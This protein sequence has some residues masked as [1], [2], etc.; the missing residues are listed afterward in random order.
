[1]VGGMPMY[2]GEGAGTRP[3]MKVNVEAVSACD[4]HILE[5]GL[6]KLSLADAAI[7][8]TAT[9]K[10]ERILAC[11]GEI[12][13]E[14]SIL[15]LETIYCEGTTLT[16]SSTSSD[17]G[18]RPNSTE[19]RIKLRISAPIVDFGETTE[20]FPTERTT[21]YT[22]F[23]DVGHSRT[24]PPPPPL[25]QVSIPPYC[26][27]DGLGGAKRGRSRVVVSGGVGRRC[28]AVSVR[29]VP[30]ATSV[31]DRLGNDKGKD[32]GGSGSEEDLV[33]LGKA[34][35]WTF[36][37]G[38]KDTVAAGNGEAV[39]AKLRELTCAIDSSKGN[40]MI[41]SVGVM[42][43][44]CIVGVAPSKK[45]YSE[46][47]ILPKEG[48][49]K[50]I[51]ND[52][53]NEYANTNA[54]VQANVNVAVPGKLEYDR[55]QDY[56]RNAG[57]NTISSTTTSATVPSPASIEG[58]PTNTNTGS[59]TTTDDCKNKNSDEV[60]YLDAIACNIWKSEMHG[61][62]VAGFRS[63][64]A[65]GP[66]CEEPIR[67]ILV[68]LEGV[69]IALTK[70][71]KRHKKKDVV[72]VAE[73]SSG[74]ES[75]NTTTAPTPPISTNMKCPIATSPSPSLLP[76]YQI[77][78]PIA[79]G[80]IIT[81]LQTSIRSSLLTRPT[82]LVEHHLHLTLHSSLTGLGPLHSTLSRRRGT[83]LTD[84]MVD[85][86]TLLSITATI[87]QINSFGLQAELAKKSSGEVTAPE[88]GSSH[89][90]V[91]SEDPFWIPTS[92]EEREE[93]GEIEGSG[94][95]S[96]GVGNTALGY[97]RMVRERKGLMVDDKRIVVVAEKQRTLARKK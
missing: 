7:E 23:Y 26:Y 44:R 81:T 58:N 34:L 17:G 4:T 27:E 1:M 94:D 42:D 6:A 39:L 71:R 20:W 18:G 31:W 35:G 86:T 62:A 43:G 49:S 63:S 97:I 76:T 74:G 12:H 78:K 60:K 24:I 5:K 91:L 25:R 53:M 22:S 21:D 37:D 73:G 30:L 56:I 38:E 54:N 50:G 69:E 32:K 66:L 19:T 45:N 55:M 96:T 84:T 29:V 85:G 40:C 8:V 51:E 75:N 90:G 65:A 14:Q 89:W 11:Q 36:E 16:N 33:L 93:Y 9:S 77:A 83:V 80:M 67:G 57:Q 70:I 82:R 41:E 95:C 15:D 47:Y 59:V 46:V 79:G 64:C 28:V 72:L 92:L 88:L 3:L 87:P 10:G 52:G 61:S 48:N 68:V 13:L 2:R